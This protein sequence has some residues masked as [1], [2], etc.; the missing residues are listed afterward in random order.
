MTLILV[1]TDFSPRSD[2]AL[3]RAVI[4]ARQTESRLFLLHALD[5]DIPD[6]LLSTRRE[7]TESLLAEMAYAVTENDDIPCDYRLALG[8]P[9]RVIGE[10]AR[11]FGPDVIVIGP[12]RRSLLKDMFVGTTA[13]RI[14]RKS[15]I[16]VLMANAVPVDTY[17]RILFATDFS[18]CSAMAVEAAANLSLAAHAK[19]TLL[20][21]FDVPD[22]LMMQRSLPQRS[23]IEAYEQEQQAE[24][25]AN[26]R[27]FVR[28][29]NWR[30]DETRV[31]Q[32]KM[33]VAETVGWIARKSRSDLVVVG[34]HGRT[35]LEKYLLGS[36]A[37]EVIRDAE[38]DILAVPPRGTTGAMRRNQ[39]E[40]G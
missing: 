35:G 5:D 26:M 39:T 2:R 4:L 6:R 33:S 31:E 28:Q 20:H 16:P 18:E 37:E 1:A 36:V 23:E 32:V 12:H 3:R 27:T 24:A 22:K 14:I 17:K 19:S 38:T 10:A 21:I 11:Q 9:F 40:E 25:S 15:S 8:D 29:L 7:L 13:E 30:P 34:T